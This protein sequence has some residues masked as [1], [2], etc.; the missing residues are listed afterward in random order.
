MQWA[1]LTVEQNGKHEPP[2]N[3]RL[4]EMQN[5]PAAEFPFLSSFAAVHTYVCVWVHVSD[6][7]CASTQHAPAHVPEM[8]DSIRGCNSDGWHGVVCVCVCVRAQ[9]RHVCFIDMSVLICA[10]PLGLGSILYF[11]IYRYWCTDRFGLLHDLYIYIYIYNSILMFG[12]L[13][14]RCHV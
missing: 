9:V 5:V 6:R 10:E 3:L 8:N 1:L 14:V 13:N 7:R 2:G 4:R 12:L 11:T